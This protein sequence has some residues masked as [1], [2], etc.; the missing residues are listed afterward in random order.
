MP[1]LEAFLDLGPERTARTESPQTHR[2]HGWLLLRANDRA[3]IVF[4]SIW[5]VIRSTNRRIRFE[6]SV[7][8]RRRMAGSGLHN[9]SR[10]PAR[11][12][13]KMLA[14]V[15]TAA[16]RFGCTIIRRYNCRAWTMRDLALALSPLAAV[17]YFLVNQDQFRELLAWAETFVH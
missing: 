7:A 15:E 17:L 14:F 5:A 11:Q 3:T 6:T 8:D 2:A 16:S 13:S 12:F 9:R 1:F 10:R 4:S